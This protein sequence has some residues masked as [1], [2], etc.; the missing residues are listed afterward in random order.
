MPTI[1]VLVE[2][3]QS[4]KPGKRY[5]ACE[6]LRVA[7]SLSPA[8]L[9]ALEKAT[10]DPN[11]GVR[12][13]AASALAV[14]NAP[15][16]MP[17]TA[18]PVPQR[19]SRF[20]DGVVAALPPLVIP[21]IL[22]SIMFLITTGDPFAWIDLLAAFTQP[23][24]VYP[25]NVVVSDVALL[26]PPIIAFLAGALLSRKAGR[27]LGLVFLAVGSCWLVFFMGLLAFT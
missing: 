9:V 6:L 19:P 13:S 10:D 26:A 7:P 3:L 20:E 4:H 1:D 23:G 18:P 11:P 21:P 25:A 16:S 12:E 27:V 17:P 14:H 5:E 2:M 22:L 24:M 15:T 8:A